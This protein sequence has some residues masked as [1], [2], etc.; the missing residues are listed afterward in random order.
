M[1][2]ADQDA[3][4]ALVRFE[5]SDTGIGI[6]TA[7]HLRLFDSFSQADA[8]T[9][10][11]YGGTGL[12][13]AICR[14]LT[15]VM[16]GEIGVTSTPGE[17]STFWF[18]IRLPWAKERGRL[19]AT[20]VPGLLTGLRVLVVD[21]NAT[22]RFVLESQLNTWGLRPDGVADARTALVRSRSAVAAG[23]PFDVA[24]LDMC[25]PDM[26]GL[27]LAREFSNDPTLR[28]SGS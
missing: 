22:N 10:R 16:G 1:N 9:T 20:P 28:G 2:V 24:V 7:D 12:G 25:M 26:D 23:Q 8:S 6:D 15:E 21:D 18:S 11:R 3:K 14:R 17:G 13:L 19:A 27:E 5:V 4:T